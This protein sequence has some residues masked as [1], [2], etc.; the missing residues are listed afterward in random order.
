MATETFFISPMVQS[1]F[2]LSS[3]A[4]SRH[5]IVSGLMRYVKDHNLID[6]QNKAIYHTDEIL[7]TL[8]NG[9]KVTSAFSAIRDLGENIC[10]TNN[11]DTESNSS[12][13][14]DAV[15]NG[16][17]GDEDGG[18]QEEEGEQWH[19]EL[20][21]QNNK[22][23]QLT[24]RCV[25]RDGESYLSING[26]EVYESEFEDYYARVVGNSPKD[27]GHGAEMLVGLCVVFA[28]LGAFSLWLSLI[29]QG[30]RHC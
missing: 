1:T 2:G 27:I 3:Y 11:D 12:S 30:L 9:K 7:Q 28:G 4:Q 6:S 18:E 14:S 19:R 8:M 17:S 15:S 26:F 25:R 23:E 22:G 20:A 10:V 13:E 16:L 24:L 5:D 21:V 29:N